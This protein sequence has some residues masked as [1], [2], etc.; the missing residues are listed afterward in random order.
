MPGEVV[1]KYGTL[2]R[3]FVHIA[4]IGHSHYIHLNE[5]LTGQ[6]GDVCPGLNQDKNGN[7]FFGGL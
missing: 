7:S 1:G 3:N 6:I 4:D 5:F 2:D